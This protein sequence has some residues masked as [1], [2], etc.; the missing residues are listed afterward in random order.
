M[1]LIFA[2]ATAV[3]LLS[4]PARAAQV[5]LGDEQF[6]SKGA[7]VAWA[8][9]WCRLFDPTFTQGK[10]NDAITLDDV[11]FPNGT[12][13][14]WSM[15]TVA[16]RPSVCPVYGYMAVSIGNYDGGT[17]KAKITPLQAKNISVLYVE[18]DFA[19]TGGVE[20]YNVLQE[21]YLTSVKG[22][23]TAKVI[24]IGWF[25]HTPKTTADFVRYGQQLG[26]YTAPGTSTAWIV[27][28]NG[29]FVTFMPATGKDYPVGGINVKAALTWLQTQGVITGDE[30]FNGMSIG[31]EPLGSSGTMAIKRWNVGYR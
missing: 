11:T 9:P 25:L 18:H 2:L 20:D 19:A 14:S 10:Y 16:Q 7:Y 26:T 4:S 24:E 21:L 3:A 1:R 13:I 28:K 12:L 15:P 5:A 22:D 31:I 23:A 8:S 6:F 30:W 17:P 27:A 29:T